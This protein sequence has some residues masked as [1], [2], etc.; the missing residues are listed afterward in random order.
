MGSGSSIPFHQPHLG[1]KVP[2]SLPGAGPE[3]FH[4]NPGLWEV[5]SERK[6]GVRGGRD[7]AGAARGRRFSERR[8]Q[9]EGKEPQMWCSIDEERAGGVSKAERLY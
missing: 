6:C 3:D 2:T 8:E 7:T 1:N 9:A 4:L 5:G